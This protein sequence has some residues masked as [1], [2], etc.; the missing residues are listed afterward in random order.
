ML[1]SLYDAP[2]T[3]AYSSYTQYFNDVTTGSSGGRRSSVSAAAGYDLLTGLGSPNVPAIVDALTGIAYAGRTSGSSGST[4]GTTD[5]PANPFSTTFIGATP[6]SGIVGGSG[7]VTLDITNTSGAIFK[8]PVTI[9][10]SLS[11]DGTYSSSDV[12]AATK[13]FKTFKLSATGSKQVR[14]KLTYGTTLSS[15]H[16]HPD[17]RNVSRRHRV[18]VGRGDRRVVH[19][20][21]RSH[22]RPVAQL[23][24]K[25]DHD[26]RGQADAGFDPHHE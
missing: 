24:R 11:A 17:C 14:L 12:V 18:G 3:S 25:R 20:A 6:T 1:Y 9:T 19:R 4:S 8:G 26:R 10:V 7:Y 16:L 23:F 2:S 5:A 22:G 21:R 13:T 15:G